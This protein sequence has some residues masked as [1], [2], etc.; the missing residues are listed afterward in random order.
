MKEKKDNS[1]SDVWAVESLGDIRRYKLEKKLIKFL[2]IVYHTLIPVVF[3]AFTLIYDNFLYFIPI[4]LILVFRLKVKWTLI[5]SFFKGRVEKRA[6]KIL[7][8]YGSSLTYREKEKFLK[9]FSKFY[10]FITNVG[11]FVF[12][13]YFFST[14]IYDKIG[15]EKTIIV[16]VTIIVLAN[17]DFFKF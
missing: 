7:N 15:F 6:S 9:L 10:S 14:M 16:L 3:T 8:K 4:L 17:K 13:M 1:L 12:L 2:E 5:S 11:L